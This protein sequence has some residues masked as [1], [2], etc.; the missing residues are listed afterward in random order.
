MSFSGRADDLL[1]RA[2]RLLGKSRVVIELDRYC[3]VS[4]TISHHQSSSYL[5]FFSSSLLV[6]VLVVVVEIKMM[7]MMDGAIIMLLFGRVFS[8]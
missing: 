6:V 7:I 3:C 4:L 8:Y 2:C 5:F 1:E